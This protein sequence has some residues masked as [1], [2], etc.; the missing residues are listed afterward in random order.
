MAGT[1][2]ETLVGSLEHQ[3]TYLHQGWFVL[4]DGRSPSLRRQLI[5]M[6]EEN[7]R[8]VGHADLIRDSVDGLVGED[9]PQP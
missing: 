6:I 4:P 8:H 5:D 7:A 3:R 9:L 2:I 1:E